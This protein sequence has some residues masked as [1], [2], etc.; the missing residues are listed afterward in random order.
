MGIQKKPK[1]KK[2]RGGPRGGEWKRY[3][4]GGEKCQTMKAVKWKPSRNQVLRK[5]PKKKGGKPERRGNT[6]RGKEK[7]GK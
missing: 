1:N 2:I 7:R 6:P 3:E 4:R 5:G